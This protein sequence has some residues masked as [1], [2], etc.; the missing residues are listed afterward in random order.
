MPDLLI[1]I[2]TEELPAGYVPILL[3]QLRNKLAESL[4]AS[5]ITHAMPKTAGT[6]RRLVAFIPGVAPRQDPL[7]TEIQGPP[8]KAA[9]DQ[10]GKPTPAGIGFARK[11]GLRPQDLTVRESPRGKY[12]FAVVEESGKE[13]IDLLPSIISDAIRTLTAP[14]SM[15]WD[16]PRFLF[17]RPIRWL[18]ALFGETIINLELNGVKA[19]RLTRGHRYMS[20]GEIELPRAHFNLYRDTLRKAKVTVEPYQ[21][22]KALRRCLK[23]LYPKDSDSLAYREL[24]PE[25]VNMLE[26]PNAAEG[27]FDDSFLDLPDDVIEAVLTYHQKCFPVRNAHGNLLP[28]FIFTLD[29][30]NRHLDE[31][32]KGNENVVRARLADGRFFWDEDRKHTLESRVPRLQSILF[33]EKLGTYLDRARR[34]E[35]LSRKIAEHL[36]C[37]QKTRDLSARAALL[38]KTDLLTQMVV[39]FPF[40]QGKM[41]GH[42]ALADGEPPEVARA[43]AEHY[44]PR[45]APD[46]VPQTTVGAIVSL[47]DKADSLVGCFAAG[48]IP[49][50]SQDPYALRRAAIGIIRLI[51]ERQLRISLN[52]LFSSAR[53]LLPDNLASVE[54]AD[55]Q[56]IEFLRDRLYQLKLDD[57]RRYD[58]LNAVMAS[59]I[60]DLVDFNQRLAAL[61]KLMHGKISA[62]L[63][64]LGERTH[65]ISSS[66]PPGID[67]N[68]HLFS[69]PEETEIWDLFQQNHQ[70]IRDLIDAR[71]YGK[72]S[73]LYVRTFSAP[74][75]NFFERVFVNVDDEKIKY[76]RMALVKAVNLLYSER[77][78]DLARIVPPQN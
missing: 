9:F 41:G 39:E 54:N 72:A 77:V 14:K 19:D 26:H 10:T 68:P 25:V 42:Y 17:A 40:L 63:V 29:R 6:P 12:C 20:K 27:H 45:S 36:G 31:I 35:E 66:L 16:D 70:R 33:Q 13:T 46:P 61:D 49:T 74:I 71:D 48:L 15:H 69:E 57:G 56:V 64:V 50:G 51:E 3:E 37:D 24:L 58:I 60:D 43:I 7:T 65:N 1:E 28:Y 23:K 21:R 18:V 73:D 59:G 4:A 38:S 32:R 78:A 52:W 67:V 76:N 53:K 55:N 75:H 11:H 5:R 2:G 62:E 47:A 8:A 22:E 30:D 34:I 44:M